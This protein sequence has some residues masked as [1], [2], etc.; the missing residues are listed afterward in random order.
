ML[1]ILFF[2]QLPY[3]TVNL[4]E[5]TY[6]YALAVN[7]TLRDDGNIKNGAEVARKVWG[8]SFPHA[9]KYNNT[10]CYYNK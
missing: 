2:F 9:S 5:A 3:Q 8:R 7:E 6:M 1:M 4:Y 10:S